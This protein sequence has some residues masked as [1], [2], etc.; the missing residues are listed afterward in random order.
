MDVGE[1]D[2]RMARRVGAIAYALTLVAVL[3]TLPFAAPTE[4]AGATAGWA[5]TAAL[6][7][8]ALAATVVSWRSRRLSLR[9]I[10]RIDLGMLAGLGL[11]GWL[12]GDGGLSAAMPVLVL[13]VV[14]PVLSRP[15]VALAIVVAALAQLPALLAVGADRDSVV[16]LVVHVFTWV[17]LCVLIALWTA[18][19]RAQRRAL[20]LHAR[21]DPLTGL[22]NRRAFEETAQAE[23]ARSVRAGQALSLLVGD[24]DGFKAVNDHHGH[25]A[26]DACLLAVAEVIRDLTRR[27]DACFRWGGD[28]FAI[29]LPEAHEPEARAVAARLSAAVA[30]R[31]RT[32]DGAPMSLPFGVAERSGEVE[33]ATLMARA[34]ADL[35]ATKVSEPG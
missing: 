31:C 25:L 17:C 34:D 26:G 15:A 12:A 27:P 33:A 14:A 3:A 13:V 30:A 11:V 6:L 8:G 35:L 28:E 4:L 18:G 1:T 10:Y 29:L 16:E 21:I 7:A 24:L 23:T 19:V 2:L 22:G 32:P 9:A 20:R 5:L